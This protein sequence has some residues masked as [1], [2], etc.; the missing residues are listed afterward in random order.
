M[1]YELK[2]IISI[3]YFYHKYYDSYKMGVT[4]LNMLKT[5][6]FCFLSK[7]TY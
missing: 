3:P 5:V 7:L 2:D 6:S 1:D 4:T